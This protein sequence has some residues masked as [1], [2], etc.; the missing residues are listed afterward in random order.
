M[1]RV[2]LSAYESL[3]S[4]FESLIVHLPSS[5]QIELG[6]IHSSIDS[7]S[8]DQDQC[9]TRYGSEDYGEEAESLRSYMSNAR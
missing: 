6:M 5:K 8:N 1:C 4:S 2:L 3:Q 9:D 7:G